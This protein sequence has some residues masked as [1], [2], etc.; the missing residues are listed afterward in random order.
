MK[1]VEKQSTMKIKESKYGDNF[2]PI[3]GPNVLREPTHELRLEL[4]DT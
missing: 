4:S 1:M 2:T 3:T